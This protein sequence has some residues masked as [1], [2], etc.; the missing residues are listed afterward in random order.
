MLPLQL[1]HLYRVVD[2]ETF[3]AARDSAWMRELF[4]PSELRTTRRPDWEYTGL[5]WYGRSTYLELFEEG[6]EGPSGSSGVAL[7]V[8]TP[9]ATP[10]IAESWQTA[11]G[12]ADH[13]RVVRPLGDDAVP[14]FHIAHAVPDRRD[15]LKVWSMEYDAEF[16]DRWH[17]GRSAARGITRKAVLERYAAVAGGPVSPLLGD[18]V[19]VTMA[20]TPGERGFFER[21]AAAFAVER[22]EVGPT[23]VI[24]GDGITFGL[25]EASEGR[26][27]VQEVVCRLRRPAGREMITLGRSAI[28][29]DDTLAVWKFR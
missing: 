24:E 8:E 11:L 17:A 25:T 10:H 29:V 4:A 12:A 16:L 13:R 19:A 27:G 7:A 1:N 3:A 2:A 21:H 26:H 5:Y 23:L 28:A 9:D 15:G 18:V 6:A 22:R 20:L 14:W